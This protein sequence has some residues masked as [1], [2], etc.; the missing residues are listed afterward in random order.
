MDGVGAVAEAEVTEA[1]HGEQ[2]LGEAALELAVSGEAC[3]ACLVN[4]AQCS[5][6]VGGAVQSL[7]RPGEGGQHEGGLGQYEQFCATLKAADHAQIGVEMAPE[8][9]LFARP[10]KE[11]AQRPVLHRCA[12]GLGCGGERI[13]G[14]EGALDVAERL[15][16][17]IALAGEV[18]QQQQGKGRVG[19]LGGGLVAAGAAM[20]CNEARQLQETERLAQRRI[21]QIEGAGMG[22]RGQKD[23]PELRMRHLGLGHNERID[24]RQLGAAQ[25]N[26]ADEEAVRGRWHGF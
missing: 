3:E 2:G 4:E 13:V 6:E 8:G 1:L 23:R 19:E 22:Q 12:Q 20:D 25:G 7:L 18:V 9:H 21:G 11:V 16:A 17:R 5:G 24:L 15:L 10:G 26:V 14:D